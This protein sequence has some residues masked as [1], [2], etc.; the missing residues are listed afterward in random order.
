VRRSARS[1]TGIAAVTAIVLASSVSAARVMGLGSP[2]LS[3]SIAGLAPLAGLLVLALYIA[4]RLLVP[5]GQRV[6][7][8]ELSLVDRLKAEN[9]VRTALLQA[10][11]FLAAIGSLYVTARSL[12]ET[13]GLNQETQAAENFTRAIDQLGNSDVDV[14]VGG[15]YALGRTAINS[16]DYR[17]EVDQVLSAFLREHD[18]F[19]GARPEIA[20]PCDRSPQRYVPPPLPTDDQ[21]VVLTLS[22]PRTGILRILNLEGID[23]RGVA[24]PGGRLEQEDLGQSEL[25][26]AHLEEA[27]LAKVILRNADVRCAS[28]FKTDLRQADL[29]DANLQGAVLSESDLTG[30]NLTGADLRYAV[31]ERVQGLSRQSLC[32]AITDATTVG[33]P[34]CR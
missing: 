11:T 1:A 4:P 2:S 14:R 6:S 30:A 18:R 33:Q 13:L 19:E 5:R 34:P 24:L 22:L 32:A 20:Q 25:A 26:G 9:D 16:S 29:D 31:L 21:A 7:D 12:T 27:H 17:F 3:G 10:F 15:I 28:L 8:V 23:L